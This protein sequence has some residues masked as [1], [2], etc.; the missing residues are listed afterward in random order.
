MYSYRKKPFF[1][2]CYLFF[3]NF[4]FQISVLKY[5]YHDILYTIIFKVK[6]KKNNKSNIKFYF[7]VKSL[8][9]RSIKQQTCEIIKTNRLLFLFYSIICSQTAIILKLPEVET[10]TPW[11]SDK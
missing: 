5:L 1:H 4:L 9:Q 7:Q 11:N 8:K 3:I 6:N 10:K 2:L